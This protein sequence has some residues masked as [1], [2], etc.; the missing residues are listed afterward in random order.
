[1]RKM[2]FKR[3]ICFRQ[4]IDYDRNRSDP[5]SFAGDLDKILQRWL[6]ITPPHAEV[7][8]AQAHLYDAA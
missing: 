4:I 5:L 6:R 8:V 7:K 2:L 3:F 1:M